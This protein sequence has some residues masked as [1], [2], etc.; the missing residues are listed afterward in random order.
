MAKEEDKR[1]TVI[2]LIKEKGPVLPVHISK[3][4]GTDII[5]AGAVLSEL[6]MQDKVKITSVK[7]GGS[8]FY[9]LKDQEKELEGLIKHL[10]EQDKKTAKLLK[11]KSIL[12]DSELTPLERVSLRQIKDYAKSIQVKLGE[13]IETF[14]RWYLIPEVNAKNLIIEMLKES[15]PEEEQKNIAETLVKKTKK[16]VVKKEQPSEKTV[17]EEE[18]KEMAKEEKTGLAVIYDYFREKGIEVLNEKTVKKGKEVNYVVKID[19]GIG[20]LRYFVKFKD[21]KRI[22]DGDI[23]L[24]FHEAGKLPLLFVSNGDLVKKAKELLDKELKGVTFRKI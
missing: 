4:I 23:S 17:D 21:K 8:P 16:K 18:V 14:W 3:E 2:E 7:A 24:A 1:E 20:K 11:E 15:D 13:N 12:K 10:N 19:S 5:Y 22:N 6:S 9:Y